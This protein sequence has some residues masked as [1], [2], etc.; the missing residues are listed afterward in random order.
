[1]D[2]NVLELF[3]GCGGL[4]YGFH[5]NKF[6]IVCSNELE[7]Q[8]GETYKQNFSE[9]DVIIGDITKTDIKQSIYSKFNDKKC[10]IIIGGP[11]CVAY[12][13]SGK[14]DPR[15][16]RGQLFKDYIETVNH[17]KP[18]ICIM[19][20]VKGIL[21][22][23]HDKDD[24]NEEEKKQA[25]KHYDL[26]KVKIDLD[27]KN[28]HKTI[29][30]D[31]KKELIKIKKEIKVSEKGMTNIRIKVSDKIKNT[32]EKIGYNV[33]YKL[34][35]AANFGVPQLRERVI[36]IAVHKDIKADI[37]FPIE[38]HCKSGDETKK[39]WVSVKDA[40]D[41]LKCKDEDK[42][43]S[44]IFTKHSPDFVEKIKN[45]PCGKAVNPKYS[46]A[47]FKCLP[48]LPSNTV[49]ENHGAVFVH[50]ENN[51]S[52]T[53]RELA[54]LQSFPDSFIFK[55]GKSSILKQL[56]NAV[57]CLLSKALAKN[58]INIYNAVE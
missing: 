47:N 20:N 39:K 4:G 56:G 46:E 18:D 48:D 32:F 34:L 45:T 28:K 31:E 23:L 3:G 11:P 25:N 24:L 29:T 54:R 12:S 37:T 57:P 55:G 27:N 44:H 2:K 38:T 36:F 52:M 14:R 6:N 5:T 50:Y 42:L 40:I 17:L 58:I 49:K 8:I 41:D 7:E 21:N 35:N 19:E 16:P 15:D 10:H 13:L 1:M 26:E 22:M 33:K 53:P 51:R 30:E 9:T 43:L